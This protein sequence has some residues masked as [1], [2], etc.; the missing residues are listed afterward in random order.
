MRL[1]RLVSTQVIALVLF[2]GL[3]CGGAGALSDQYETPPEQDPAKV[4]D[5]KELGPGYAVLSPVRSDGFLRIYELQGDQ[6]IERIE[7][8][9]LLKLRL[10]EIQA[11]VALTGLKKRCQLC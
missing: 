9:G 6:G 1:F 4:L 7:G 5:G 10:A 11:Y 3:L 8:D 2:T